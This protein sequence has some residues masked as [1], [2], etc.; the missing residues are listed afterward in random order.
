MYNNGGEG[1]TRS[2]SSIP[3]TISSLKRS[4]VNC[5]VYLDS[6]LDIIHSSTFRAHMIMIMEVLHSGVHRCKIGCA[7][8]H[9]AA[10]A[11]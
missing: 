8:P 11:C 5:K 7:T 6:R 10:Y 9:S 1:G 4:G 2:S 3:T